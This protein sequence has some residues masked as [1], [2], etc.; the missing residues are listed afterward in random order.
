ME[1][2]KTATANLGNYLK[3]HPDVNLADIAYT[4]Q[5]GRQALE[6][7]RFIVCQNHQQAIESLSNIN[8]NSS[9]TQTS[10][11][12]NKNLIFMFSGQGSQ[13]ENMG[14][15]LY[16]TQSVFRETVDNCCDLL[17]PHLGFDLRTIIYPSLTPSIPDSNLE[18]ALGVIGDN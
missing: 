9:I 5:I 12:A 10:Q 4:L 1:A 14:R 18:S 6:Q 8:D 13:Y 15:E 11:A 2:L 3:S 16:Q 7:R 17:K